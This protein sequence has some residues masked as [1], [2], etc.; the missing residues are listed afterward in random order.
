MAEWSRQTPWRQGQLLSDEALKALL[1]KEPPDAAIVISHD[2]DLAQSPEH[3]PLVELIVGRIVEKFDGN[4]TH[5]KNARRLHLPIGVDGAVI[6]DLTATQK[7]PVPKEALAAFQPDSS[8]RPSSTASATLQQWLALRYRRAAFPDEF[9][10]RLS[11]TK[12]ADR[13][14]GRVKTG[15]GLFSGFF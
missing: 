6:L 3:E 7:I 8:L 11:A 14:G 10:R 1:G 12:M 9:D 4:Y 13:L 15:G 2:C 5:A